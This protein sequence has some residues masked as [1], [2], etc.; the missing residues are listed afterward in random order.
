MDA[1]GLSSDAFSNGSK[2]E[3]AAMYP[4][5]VSGRMPAVPDGI[6]W[7]APY[8]RCELYARVAYQASADHGLT[9]LPSLS[10]RL[11]NQVV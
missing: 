10:D 11:S 3:I 4:D 8:Q 1:P 2:V 6:R 9:V 5:L 7:S